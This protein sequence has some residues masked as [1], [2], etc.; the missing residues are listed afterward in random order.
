MKEEEL[1][2]KTYVVVSLK[3]ITSFSF[4]L[5]LANIHTQFLHSPFWL[6]RLWFFSLLLLEF[7]YI[8]VLDQLTLPRRWIGDCCPDQQTKVL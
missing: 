5:L 2:S 4:S 3:I 8:V 7:L 6:L 1:D